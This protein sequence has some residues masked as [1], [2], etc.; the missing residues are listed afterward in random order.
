MTQLAELGRARESGQRHER[1]RLDPN[2]LTRLLAV[3]AA[4]VS[5][6]PRPGLS[7]EE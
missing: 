6:L 4:M 3:E 5:S 2:A 1:G 7:L